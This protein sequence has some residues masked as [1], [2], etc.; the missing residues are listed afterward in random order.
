[1]P[2]I[3]KT[4]VEIGLMDQLSEQD[5]PIHRLDPRAKIISTI[6]FVIAVVSFDRYEI[7]G[8]LP[9]LLYPIVLTSLAEIP[10]SF[11]LRR[12]L[13]VAPFAFFLGMFNPFIDRQP[14]LVLGG[15][16]LSGGWISFFSLLLRFGNCALSF[17]FEYLY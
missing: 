14:M 11:L 2:D 13:L 15:V 8:L 9:F 16:F 3:E 6:L 1:M 12:I 10:W 17:G 4:F 5:T 7:S